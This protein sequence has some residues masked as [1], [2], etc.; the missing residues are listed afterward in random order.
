MT[1]LSN[2]DVPAGSSH[3]VR[4]RAKRARYAAEVAA[5][6]SGRPAERFAKALA[7]VQGVLGDHQDSV[8]AQAWL[9][10]QG[11]SGRRAYAAGEMSA[12]EMAAAARA[13]ADFPRLWRAASAKPLR[14]WMT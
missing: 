11:G 12:L 6:V 14:A 1:M 7:D 3:Q 10:S 8:T 9:R 5:A 2:R 4:I 13:R